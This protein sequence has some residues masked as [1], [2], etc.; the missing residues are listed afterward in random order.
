MRFQNWRY[1]EWVAGGKTEAE[2]YD[3]D[4][5]PGEYRNLASLPAYT[6]II[7]KLKPMLPKAA[8]LLDALGRPFQ[9]APPRP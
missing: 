9:P 7:A 8:P 1:T 5:D 6:S 2:L 4:K 3:L